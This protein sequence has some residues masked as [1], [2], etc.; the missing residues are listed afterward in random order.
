MSVDIQPIT[1]T[2][3]DTYPFTVT[4]VDD[5]GAVL[6]L[7]GASFTLTVNAEE[8]PDETQL[9][10]FSL[11]GVVA[12]PLTGEIEFSMSE[13]D[14]DLVGLHYYDIQMT[15]VQGYIRTVMRGPFEMRQDITKLTAMPGALEISQNTSQAVLVEGGLACGDGFG[16]ADNQWYRRFHL[17]TDHGI[18]GGFQVTGVLFT[19]E[20]LYEQENPMD[21]NQ[22]VHL[23]FHS[24]AKAD[25]MLLANL[26]LIGT[27]DCQIPKMERLVLAE[28]VAIQSS[29]NFGTLPDVTTHDLVFEISA[30]LS[31]DPEGV[32][33][34]FYLGGNDDGETRE[35]YLSSV[36]CGFPEPTL[37]ADLGFPNVHFVMIVYGSEVTL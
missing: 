8:D 29:G 18:V 36:T 22:I 15:D 27:Q 35:G 20:G 1:R 37:L 31:L 32:Q 11:T 19:A 26:T 30:D 4:L 3:G 5:A 17:D 34:G 24:I 16:T 23:N 10:E 2:R 13:S 33:Y 14:A 7:T 6:D 9:P 28:G 21:L 25:P 12:A